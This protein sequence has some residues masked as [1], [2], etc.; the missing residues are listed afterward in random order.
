MEWI[1]LVSLAALFLWRRYAGVFERRV[2]SIE[3]ISTDEGEAIVYCSFKW[4]GRIYENGYFV[5]KPLPQQAFFVRGYDTLSG[6][7][8]LEPLK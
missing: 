4:R 1:F 3:I 5:G 8:F 6:C 2:S 7:W